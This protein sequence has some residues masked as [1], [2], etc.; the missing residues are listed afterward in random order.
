MT[1]NYTRRVFATFH[2]DDGKEL[3]LDILTIAAVRGDGEDR[4]ILFFERQDG[5]FRVRGCV[6]EIREKINAAISGISE[7]D[8]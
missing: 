7:D 2:T 3:W 1:I 4:S 8:L 6:K 5:T